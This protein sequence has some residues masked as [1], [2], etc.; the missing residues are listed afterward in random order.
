[1]STGN[2]LYERNTLVRV[3]FTVM[4]VIWGLCFAAAGVLIVNS[5]FYES[6]C[7]P[8]GGPCTNVVVSDQFKSLS[9]VATR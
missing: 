6:N 9:W 3:I 8:M 7:V 5:Q 1:M 2:D 4:G